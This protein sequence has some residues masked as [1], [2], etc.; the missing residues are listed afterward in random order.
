MSKSIIGRLS[1]TIKEF[2]ERIRR[3]ISLAP[4]FPQEAE[5]CVTLGMLAAKL[6]VLRSEAVMCHGTQE[7]R[8]KEE[9][10]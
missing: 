7:E 6:E 4:T 9:R 8:E 5:L 3:Y 10:S 2:D 1:D